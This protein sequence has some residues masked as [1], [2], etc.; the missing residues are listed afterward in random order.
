MVQFIIAARKTDPVLTRLPLSGCKK[1]IIPYT[2]DRMLG[3][4]VPNRRLQQRQETETVSI[5]LQAN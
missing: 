5:I 2:V 3:I 4:I 1:H